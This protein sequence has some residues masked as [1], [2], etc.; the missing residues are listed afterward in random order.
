MQRAVRSPF[1]SRTR[2]SSDGKN[3]RVA[4]EGTSI[5]G[6]HI[7]IDGF[8]PIELIGSGG[9]S[10]VYRARQDGFDRD[11]AIKVL[12]VGL[13][14][15][16]KRKA[17]EREC[18][19]MGV[20]SQHPNIVTVFNAAFTSEASESDRRPCIVMQYYS[21]GTL[22]E[23]VKQDG[24]LSLRGGLSLGVQMAGA[25]ETAHRNGVI[26]RDIKPTNLFVNDYGQPA[27]GDFG[28]S[29]FDDDRTIT[30][31][32]G[33]LTVHYAPPELIE[34]DSATAT[35]D[36]YSLAATLFTL[37]AG[38]RPFP[39][40]EGQS[41]GELARRIL[42]EP[43]PRL[44]AE[45]VPPALVDLLRRAMAKRP[46]QRPAS[47]AAFG[48]ELQAVQASLGFPIT[49]MSL[50][51]G[52]GLAD[53]GPATTETAD[54]VAATSSGPESIIGE[55]AST[56][57]LESAGE[58]T[59]TV[60]RAPVSSPTPAQSVLARADSGRPEPAPVTPSSALLSRKTRGVLIATGCVIAL[61]AAAL[62]LAPA[63]TVDDQANT[64]DRLTATTSLVDDDFFA[65][66]PA[67]SG[68]SISETSDPLVLEV[69]WSASA[70]ATGFQIQRIDAGA[71]T[72]VETEQ[73][74]GR[75]ELTT[76]D[77]A[78]CLVVRSIGEGGRLS[79]DSDIICRS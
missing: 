17:F 46:H 64:S 39:R 41:V 5:D 8:E 74:P 72:V 3:R 2:P 31:G 51:G 6:Q 70:A 45:G 56:S 10:R 27:L 19:A 48:R 29:S 40:P 59:I 9:F 44:D 30:G 13:E 33:G 32:G 76:P 20:L 26:H 38:R 75:V 42:L 4:P 62:A 18:R 69:E 35:S 63:R 60:A 22:G 53:D 49:E 50:T 14:S 16:A 77:E 61:G 25:L 43:P 78:V 12:S 11:V 34:G 15:A 52:T 79:A 47:A 55:A 1:S 36:V 24:P 67:P 7:A 66:P 54:P 28:I 37:L 71:G 57:P 68:V 58:S 21:G 23:R 65:A 73:S